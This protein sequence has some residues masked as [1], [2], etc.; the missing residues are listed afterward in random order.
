MDGM[1][2]T[3]PENLGEKYMM[4][5]NISAISAVDTRRRTE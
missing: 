3:T 4:W 5:K 1:E 2:T